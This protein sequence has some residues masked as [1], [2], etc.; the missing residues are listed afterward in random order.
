MLV[1]LWE[2][3]G[4]KEAALTLDIELRGAPFLL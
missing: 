3:A 2:K 1:C 4:L